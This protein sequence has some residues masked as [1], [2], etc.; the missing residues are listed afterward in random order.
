[1]AMVAIV[2]TSNRLLVRTETVSDSGLGEIATAIIGPCRPRSLSRRLEPGHDLAEYRPPSWSGPGAHRESS[3]DVDSQMSSSDCPG[4]IGVL[5]RQALADRP[6]DPG[7]AV[8][9]WQLATVLGGRSCHDG[10]LA[11]E[12]HDGCGAVLVLGHRAGREA[13]PAST[14]LVMGR[15]AWL[16]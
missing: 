8:L 5:S 9:Q 6:T 12:A 1:M 7:P 10:F 3:W 16:P 15:L 11:L 2:T 13:I 14:G 4:L